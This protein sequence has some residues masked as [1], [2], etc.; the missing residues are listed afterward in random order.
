MASREL[1]CWLGP[2]SVHLGPRVLD[3]LGRWKGKATFASGVDRVSF[4]QIS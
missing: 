3:A 1:I 2:D 4:G